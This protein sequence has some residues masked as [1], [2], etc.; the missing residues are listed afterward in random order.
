MPLYHSDAFV[1]RTYTLGER[2][3]IVVFFTC[4]FGK[5]RAVAS[6]SHSTRRPMAGY[7]QPL[8][9]LRAIFFRRPSQ[10]L[11]RIDAVDLIQAFR[12]LHEDFSYLRCGLYLTELIDVTTRD[13]EPVPELFTLLRR[14]LEQLPQ[15]ADTA[16]LLRLFEL[17]VL[18]LIG[19]TPQVLYCTRCAEDVKGDEGRYSPQLGGLLCATCATAVRQTLAVGRTAL[20]FLRQAI[21][22][23]ASQAAARRLDPTAQQELERLLQA[24]LTARLGRE[25]KSYAFL[26]L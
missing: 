17:R 13:H 22:S 26:Q 10:A 20:A 4:E 6:R 19:Y 15:V 7:Y 11:Y 9:L 16:M 1:L 24:H 12:P 5:L 2:D 18:M 25:L 8:I 14:T 3:Q 21:A 23:H